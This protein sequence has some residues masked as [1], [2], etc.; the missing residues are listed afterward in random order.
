MDFLVNRIVHRIVTRG[1]RVRYCVGCS[2]AES[3]LD[4]YTYLA[5]LVLAQG[6]RSHYGTYVPTQTCIHACSDTPPLPLPLPPAAT[7]CSPCASREQV[8]RAEGFSFHRRRQLESA[9]TGLWQL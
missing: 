6:H 5:F 7:V 3:G 2:G 9:V 8:P 4:G 1:R